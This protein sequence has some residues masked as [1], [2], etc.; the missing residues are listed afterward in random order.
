MSGLLSLL[1]LQVFCFSIFTLIAMHFSGVIFFDPDDTLKPG[2]YIPATH[3]PAAF[4][5]PERRWPG[6]PHILMHANCAGAA[7][8]RREVGGFF[9]LA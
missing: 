2:L 8:F 6:D 9:D 5:Y 4:L 1:F 3:L 7:G